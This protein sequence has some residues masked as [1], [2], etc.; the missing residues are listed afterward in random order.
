MYRKSH[1]FWEIQEVHPLKLIFFQIL[2][3]RNYTL[4]SAIVDV[5]ATYLEAVLWKPFKLSR[6]ILNDVSSIK[7]APSLQCWFHS[8]GQV[9]ISWSQV[10]SC[11]YT[12]VLSHWVFFFLRKPWSKPSGVLEHCR[13]G[14]MIY[15]WLWRK[16]I[17][18]KEPF[19]CS[20]HIWSTRNWL[21]TGLEF[22]YRVYLPTW[23]KQMI[24]TLQNCTYKIQYYSH[25][26]QYLS[27]VSSGR[28][29]L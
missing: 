27:S 24:D 25:T 1:C 12:T 23:E 13:E 9:K 4:L 10:R 14:E 17:L 5:L 6:R 2:P 18:V 19:Y 26:N 3:L 7:K 8:S 16:G 11:G 28:A 20:G 15:W 29:D 21:C 22:M